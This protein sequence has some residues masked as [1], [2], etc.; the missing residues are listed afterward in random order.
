MSKPWSVKRLRVMSSEDDREA[1][2]VL[3]QTSKR[4]AGEAILLYSTRVAEHAGDQCI[5]QA[6]LTAVCLAVD[7]RERGVMENI[8][9][10]YHGA[11]SKVAHERRHVEPRH[12][13][14]VVSLQSGHVAHEAQLIVVEIL[15]YGF[16]APFQALIVHL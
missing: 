5:D 8:T 6:R 3:L 15:D 12:E 10:P 2:V 16:S 1:L 4:S 13:R 9:A 14:E 7:Y 11:S